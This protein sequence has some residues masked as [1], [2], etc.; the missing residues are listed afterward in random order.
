M[1]SNITPID[2]TL[3]A[4][5]K[6]RTALSKFSGLN[7]YSTPAAPK[8]LDYPIQIPT[9]SKIVFLDKDRKAKFAGTITGR[10]KCTVPAINEVKAKPSKKHN[11]FGSAVAAT[12]AVD[13]FSSAILSGISGKLKENA[14]SE[15]EKLLKGGNSGANP[16]GLLN[17]THR[18][19][20]NTWS[21]KNQPKDINTPIK[22]PLVSLIK[23][24][25]RKL[26]ESSPVFKPLTLLTQDLHKLYIGYAPIVTAKDFQHAQE[27]FERRLTDERYDLN[28]WDFYLIAPHVLHNTT[29][30]PSIVGPG[31]HV[32]HK[33][34]QQFVKRMSYLLGMGSMLLTEHS[35]YELR[36]SVALS[37]L[38]LTLNYL[39]D[40]LSDKSFSIDLTSIIAPITLIYYVDS[41]D[42]EPGA[43]AEVLTKVMVSAIN[44]DLK[45]WGQGKNP[46]SAVD[47]LMLHPELTR[48]IL[49]KMPEPLESVNVYKPIKQIRPLDGPKVCDQAVAHYARLRFNMVAPNVYIP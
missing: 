41:M 9:G 22:T 5:R 44:Y 21:I 33:V 39:Y 6:G 2:P 29:P 19:T 31:S 4:F 32:G 37:V 8:C 26:I 30:L 45:G 11:Y 20:V 46:Y 42:T 12:D 10:F 48:P 16:V 13:A 24:V 40:R 3:K 34:T 25:I 35:P 28:P 17:S 18:P 23:F 47:C 43:M 38:N 27:Y 7:A 14:D 49:R 15:G 36:N 1:K